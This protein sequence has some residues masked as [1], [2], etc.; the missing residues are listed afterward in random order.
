VA[1]VPGD[2]RNLKVTFAG[3]LDQAAAVAAKWSEGRWI[4]R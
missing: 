1:I 3:D 4:D 2:P